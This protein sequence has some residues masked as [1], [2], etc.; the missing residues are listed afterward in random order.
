M[1]T[2]AGFCNMTTHYRH[3]SNSIKVGISSPVGVLNPDRHFWKN[4][5]AADVLTNLSG[6]ILCWT[7]YYTDIY[8]CAIKLDLTPLFLALCA[9]CETRP[10]PCSINRF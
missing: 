1:S 5:R 9:K 4:N 6:K 10:K 2:S 3:F 8:P 7:L